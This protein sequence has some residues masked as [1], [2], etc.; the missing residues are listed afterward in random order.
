M[1]QPSTNSTRLRAR[2]LLLLLP[3]AA[4]CFPLLYA[5]ATPELLGFPFFYWCQF[6]WVVLTSALLWLYYRLVS[7]SR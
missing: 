5:R 7:G 2:H 1:A 4:L 6:V 3:Y